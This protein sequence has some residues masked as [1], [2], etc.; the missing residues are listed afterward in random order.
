VPWSATGAHHALRERLGFEH[1][2]ELAQ[3]LCQHTPVFATHTSTLSATCPPAHACMDS[4]LTRPQRV[5][6]LRSK[7]RRSAW[8]PLHGSRRV[9]RA[10]WPLHQ[11]MPQALPEPARAFH[12]WRPHEPPDSPHYQGILRLV[13]PPAPRRAPRGCRRAHEW[14]PQL[15]S[16]VLQHATTTIAALTI[17]SQTPTSPQTHRGLAPVGLARIGRGAMPLGRG[18]GAPGRSA[19][20]DGP[21]LG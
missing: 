13:P 9:S 5:Q 3:P 19:P 21:N 10:A 6:I 12:G 17:M 4:A 16:A 15:S 11:L 18:A 2:R 7:A 14:R 8:P 20:G 1:S